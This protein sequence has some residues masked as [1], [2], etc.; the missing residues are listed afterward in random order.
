MGNR[1]NI[2]VYSDYLCPWCYIAA[3]RLERIEGEYGERVDVTWKSFPLLR[4]E[5]EGYD[6]RPHM[7][8]SWLRARGEEENSIRYNPWPDLSPLPTSSLPAQEAAKCARLQGKEA[9]ERFHMMLLRA[10]FE[11]NRD[12]SDREVLISLAV[13]A[14]LD[15]ERFTSDFDSGSQRGEVLADYREG[16]NDTRFAGVPTAIF[17]HTVVLEGAVPI[18]MY[19]RAV[20]VLLKR[21]G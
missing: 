13:E 18:E 3:V 11:Q 14:Q 4:Q 17:D 8:R 2:T 12:I 5:I 6:L 15:E 19:R 10:L 9:F 1:I 20:D 21:E 7:T 16:L